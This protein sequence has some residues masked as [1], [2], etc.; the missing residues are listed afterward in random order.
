MVEDILKAATAYRG[1]SP[2]GK[3]LFRE[4]TGLTSTKRRTGSR[5]RTASKAKTGAVVTGK[6]APRVRNIDPSHAPAEQVG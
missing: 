5:R 4:E 1:L 2:I 3:R 6:R